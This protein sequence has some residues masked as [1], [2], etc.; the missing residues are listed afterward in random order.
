LEQLIR[1]ADSRA[2]WTA[3]NSNDTSTP[4]MAMTTSSSTSVNPDFRAQRS[5]FI[6]FPSKSGSRKKFPERFG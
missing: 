1:R 3:G 6:G 4:M 5:A 2:D